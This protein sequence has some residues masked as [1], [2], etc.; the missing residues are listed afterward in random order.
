M[1]KVFAILFAIIAACAFYGA[2]FQ[3]APWHIATT[4]ACL[5][6]SILFAADSGDTETP[7]LSGK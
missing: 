7:G 1:N 5:F 4:I 2:I 6:L 3:N